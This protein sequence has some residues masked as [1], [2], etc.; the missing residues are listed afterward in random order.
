MVK[1]S[2]GPEERG[3]RTL[4]YRNPAESAVA[5]NVGRGRYILMPTL[6]GMPVQSAI[7]W[8]IKPFPIP[9]WTVDPL[10]QSLFKRKFI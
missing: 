8:V 4:Y 6:K 3:R 10:A 7:R 1:L 2:C 5:R 9:V